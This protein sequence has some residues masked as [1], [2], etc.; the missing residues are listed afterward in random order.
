MIFAKY[1]ENNPRDFNYESL[2][3]K[4]L[5]ELG[6]GCGLAGLACMMRGMITTL[7]DLDLVVETLTKMNSEVFNH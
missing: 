2:K 6:S 1:I 4:R 5:L 3:D 7:T